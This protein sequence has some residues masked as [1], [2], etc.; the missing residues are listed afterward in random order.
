MTEQ[1]R[2]SGFN[3]P[4]APE[5]ANQHSRESQPNRPANPND[6]QPGFLPPQPTQNQTPA[7][8]PAAQAPAAPAVDP[9]VAALLAALSGKQ[10]ET[11]AAAPAAAPAA[12]ASSDPF[13]ASLSGILNSSGVDVQRAI[14]KAVEYGDIGLIDK[15]YIDSVG[16]KNS[17]HL[18]RMAE[19]LVQHTG[20]ESAA[21]EQACYALAGG[22]SNF[23]AAVGVFTQHAPKHLQT[24]IST[25]MDSGVRAQSDA[26]AQMIIDF[27]KGNGGM[28]QPAGLV[29]GGAMPGAEAALS[30]DQFQA[31][32]YKLDKNAPGYEQRRGELF[33]RRAM[34]KKLGR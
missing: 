5:G 32:L 18:M 7:Q 1:V 10:A 4:P 15:T 20:R 17:E 14:A 16:G 12:P 21:A 24:I 30:K 9:T 2:V 3:V 33:G 13:V 11:T 34:G 25:M 6:M 29:T 22:E 23:R 8:A 27:A 26:G 28:V 19:A 31:E